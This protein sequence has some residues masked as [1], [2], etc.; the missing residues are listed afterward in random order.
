M[1]VTEDVH[2]YGQNFLDKTRM[3]ANKEHQYEGVQC[4]LAFH[5]TIL[6][7]CAVESQVIKKIH[8]FCIH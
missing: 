3:K 8:Q 2:V 7:C 4:N 6:I 5:A 1:W